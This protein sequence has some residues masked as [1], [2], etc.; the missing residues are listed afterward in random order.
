MQW[1]RG[2][3]AGETPKAAAAPEQEAAAREAAMAWAVADGLH[4]SEAH[5]GLPERVEASALCVGTLWRP[6]AAWSSTQT[7]PRTAWSP[8]ARPPYELKS[9]ILRAHKS[10]LLEAR[11]RAGKPERHFFA[12]GLLRDL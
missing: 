1:P 12:E 10:K 3:A 8:A 2:A 7:G 9:K 6:R 5:G 4:G 11:T